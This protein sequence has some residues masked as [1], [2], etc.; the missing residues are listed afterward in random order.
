MRV[1]INKYNPL[2][3]SSYIKLP[4]VLANKK[5]IINVKNENDNKCFLWSILAALYPVCENPQRVSKYKEHEFKFNDALKGIEFPVKIQDIEKFEN[6]VKNCSINVYHHDECYNVCPLKIT[7]DEKKNHIDLLYL[8]ENKNSHYCLI[9]DLWKLVGSQISKYEHKKYLCK[10][11][12]QSFSCAEK[13][14]DH[15]NYCGI[16]KPVK[17]VLPKKGD[18]ICEFKNY[19]HSR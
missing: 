5:A 17:T 1:N 14:D 7:K 3:A 8:T 12:L 13:L 6:R 4:E 18:N 11:C 10:M 16:N 15:K 9:K 19:N 2:R